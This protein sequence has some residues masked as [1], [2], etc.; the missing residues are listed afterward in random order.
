[1]KLPISHILAVLLASVCSASL[2]AEPP[3]LLPLQARLANEAGTPLPNGYVTVQFQ[4]FDSPSGASALWAGEVHRATISDGLINVILGTKNPLPASR[5][6]DP[7]KAFFGSTIYLQITVDTDGPDGKPDGRF[8]VEDKPLLPRQALVPVPYAVDSYNAQK[9]GGRDW[10]DLLQGADPRTAK[11]DGIRISSNS[12]SNATIKDAQIDRRTLVRDVVESLCPAGSIVAFAGGSASLPKGWLLCDGRSLTKTEHPTL[13]A[14]I[15]TAW[16]TDSQETFRLP[17]LRGVFLRGVDDSPTEGP[18]GNDPDR[19]AR[20]PRYS[21][22]VSGNLHGTYQVDQLKSHS[23]TF[24]RATLASNPNAPLGIL[25]DDIYKIADLQYSTGINP[26]GGS[27][28]RPK[29][30]FVNYIIKE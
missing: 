25:A 27:E 19:D 3:R 30:A 14:A 26:T 1:M 17:D 15:G 10:S 6:D 16:G 8:T 28:T 2:L 20:V 21:G 24:R 7:D 11:L 23:H 18:S 29:N 22:G 9:L 4:I 13:F 5:P 12:V